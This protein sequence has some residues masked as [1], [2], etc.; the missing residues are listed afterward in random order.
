MKQDRLNKCL[1]MHCHKS[2]TDTPWTLLRLQRG[3]LVPK[4][5][6]TDIL[7]NSSRGMAWLGLVYYDPPPPPPPRFKTLRRLCHCHYHWLGHDSLK[8]SKLKKKRAAFFQVVRHCCRVRHNP[9]NPA[10]LQPPNGVRFF[11]HQDYSFGVI[12]V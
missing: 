2:N 3:L 4:N 10:V 1:L 9:L 8:T 12:V 11:S 5:Y 6:A 7:G